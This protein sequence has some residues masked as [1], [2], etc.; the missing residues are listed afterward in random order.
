MLFVMLDYDDKLKR[1][2]STPNCA[3]IEQ[4]REHQSKTGSIISEVR[5]T[6]A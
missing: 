5:K 4:C 6:R 3:E 2:A 1:I